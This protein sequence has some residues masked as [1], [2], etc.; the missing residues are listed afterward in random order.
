VNTPVVDYLTTRESTDI[1][2]DVADLMDDTQVSRAITYRDYQSVSH[3]VSTGTYTPTYTDLSVRGVRT[4][5]SAKEVAA[6]AGLYQMGDLR[7]FLA[8]SDL[9]ATPTR[10]DRIVDGSTTYEVIAWEA[11]PISMTWTIIARRVK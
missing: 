5:L 2:N 6:G 1:T 10:E 8:Q 3:T 9:S 11:D 4:G 7:Y